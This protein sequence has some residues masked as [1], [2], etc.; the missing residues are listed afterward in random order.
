MEEFIRAEL[1]FLH[2]VV[3]DVATGTRCHLRPLPA[4]MREEDVPFVGRWG[5]FVVG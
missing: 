5:L 2:Q 4:G 1:A 3:L